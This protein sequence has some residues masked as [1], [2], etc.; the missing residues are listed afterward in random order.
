MV[1][2]ERKE[3]KEQSLTASDLIMHKVNLRIA[4]WSTSE[5]SMIALELIVSSTMG[6][7][8][9]SLGSFEKLN[10]DGAA[11]GSQGRKSRGA[12]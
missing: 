3:F 6:K 9:W 2:V 7:Q 5:V 8:P 12:S 1:S 4:K 10:V 11:G